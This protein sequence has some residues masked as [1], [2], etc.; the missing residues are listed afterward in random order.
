MYI[1]QHL[2]LEYLKKIN[3]WGADFILRNRNLYLHFS[4]FLNTEMVQLV[5]ILPKSQNLNVSHLF[6]QLS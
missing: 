5:E 3:P 1:T 6:L 4:S 2:M